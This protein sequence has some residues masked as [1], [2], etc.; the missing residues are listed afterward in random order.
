M[1]LSRTFSRYNSLL[2]EIRRF[3]PTPPALVAPMGVTP[4]EYLWHYRKLD[5]LGYC[6][7]LLA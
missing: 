7:A 2:L 3:E 4:V 6:V 5:S 1:R